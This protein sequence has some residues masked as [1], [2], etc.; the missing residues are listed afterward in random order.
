MAAD[1]A[2]DIN[3]QGA[4]AEWLIQPGIGEFNHKSVYPTAASDKPPRPQGG[5]RKLINDLRGRRHLARPVLWILRGPSPSRGKQTW[6]FFR[7]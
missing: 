6:A 7:E 5:N 2:W 3:S 4:M 1:L